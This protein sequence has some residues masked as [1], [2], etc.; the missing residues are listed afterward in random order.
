MH[1]LRTRQGSLAQSI[2]GGVLS[3]LMECSKNQADM[4]SSV[5]YEY[6]EADSGRQQGECS[7]HRKARKLLAG[8][9]LFGNASC[10]NILNLILGVKNVQ[11]ASPSWA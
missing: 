8:T 11:V 1:E 10:I 7:C 5:P 2:V 9:L 3:E 4:L 6:D